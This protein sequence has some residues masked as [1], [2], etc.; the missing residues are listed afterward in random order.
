M[1]LGRW[2]TAPHFQWPW[3]IDES[4]K[5]YG[6]SQEGFKV[7]K[8]LSQCTRLTS[9]YVLTLMI[10]TLPSCL[11]AS[12][13]HSYSAGRSII[14]NPQ[15]G[16]PLASQPQPLLTVWDLLLLWGCEW[17]WV[18]I[19]FHNNVTDI[20]WLIDGL[21]AGTV[22]G[23]TD[24]S[25]DGKKLSRLCS[26]GWILHNTTTGTHLA[27]S[28]CECSPGAGSYQGKVLGLCALQLLLLA[29]QE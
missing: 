11:P 21:K 2:I 18:S 20:S 26:S 15:S 12:I 25:F 27:G 16:P 29:F 8:H 5:L 19:F 17:M 14:L 24:G 10:D 13:T 22:I 3:Y 6:A 9:G 7:Y 1:S 28:F 4:L 23:C